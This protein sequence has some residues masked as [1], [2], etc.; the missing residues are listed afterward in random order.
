MF[1]S[2]YSQDITSERWCLYVIQATPEPKPR[3]CK[4]YVEI[5]TFELAKTQRQDILNA[6][7]VT[8]PLI[9][10][11]IRSLCCK[12]AKHVQRMA[13]SGVMRQLAERWQLEIYNANRK[14]KQTQQ[15]HHLRSQSTA[16][17]SALVV[18]VSYPPAGPVPAVPEFRPHKANPEPSECVAHKIRDPIGTNEHEKLSGSYGIVYGFTRKR[19][20]GF[21]KIGCTGRS[22]L[23]RVNDWKKCGYMPELV[24]RVREVLHPRRVELLSH[25]ELIKEWREEPW[26]KQCKHRHE[27]WF[28]VSNK[29]AKE[30]VTSWA[31]FLTLA[32]P[33]DERGDLNYAWKEV[34]DMLVERGKA[35]T[36]K[37]LLEEH[38][39]REDARLQKRKAEMARSAAE[40][41]PRSARTVKLY[42][43]GRKQ[44]PERSVGLEAESARRKHETQP[45]AAATYSARTRSSTE[46]RETKLTKQ[47]PNVWQSKVSS[48]T[49]PP[50]G[51]MGYTSHSHSSPR[52]DQKVQK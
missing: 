19:S 52:L 32:E 42:S 26:C 16:T 38:Y 47:P 21:V 46:L 20:P 41:E 3:R 37:R 25:Y 36:G 24:F 31:N 10:N 8:I 22:D 9:E 39:R 14:A 33:Y 4:N 50:D 30:V 34:I 45:P 23:R 17:S 5:S 48:S 11:Y 44:L 12:R 27:E 35:I 2:F 6:Q 13:D 7:A 29:K 15:R 18:P 1:E 43:S 28:E 49:I 40:A 51:V